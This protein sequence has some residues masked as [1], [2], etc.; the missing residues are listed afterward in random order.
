MSVIAII[1]IKSDSKGI[2][3][4]CY[5]QFNGRAL[6]HWAYGAA[7]GCLMIDKIYVSSS[8]KWI[9]RAGGFDS[10]RLGF[11]ERPEELN[12]DTELLDVMKHAVAQI[13]VP[14]DIFVQVQPSKPLTKPSDLLML[15]KHFQN[16]KLNSLFT[17]QEIK[18]A[19]NGEY[20]QA[21]QLGKKNFKSC[22]I[23]KIWDY[24][25]LMT[26]KSG[27]WGKGEKHED[28][29]IDQRHIEI[30]DELDFRIAEALMKAGF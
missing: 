12:G 28:F 18:T 15:I 7:E 19:V 5:R 3:M 17:V 13:G 6:W 29:F 14:G 22:A 1:P 16:N 11:I 26:A 10:P 25:T 4:K 21:K 24:E 20:K 23:A 8:D 27:T 30:D 2:P 9:V